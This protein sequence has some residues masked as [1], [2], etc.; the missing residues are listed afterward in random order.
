MRAAR[1]RLFDDVMLTE[2]RRW[3]ELADER[4][5]QYDIDVFV[6]ACN[7]D[8]GV[9]DDVL[10]GGRHVQ[11][12]DDRVVLLGPHEM[13]LL[14]YANP[15][16]WHS[17]WELDEDELYRRIKRLADQLENPATSIF[18]LHAPRTTPAWTG[19]ARSRRT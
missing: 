5:A 1:E 13:I 7:D 3:I 18:N 16:P 17:P 4:I 6:M 2:L 14:S 9:C 11:M 15:T 19:R 12:R 8:P 10:A